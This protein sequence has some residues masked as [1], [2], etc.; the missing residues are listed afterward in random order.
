MSTTQ[1]IRSSST[2]RELTPA[3]RLRAK[4]L[5][6]YFAKR[7]LGATLRY[8]LLI[9]LSFLILYPFIVKLSNS[10]M[11][12]Q[13]LID[14]TVRFIPRNFTL[15]NYK[16]VI[17]YTDFLEG[18]KN[19]FLISFLSGILQMIVCTVIGYGLAKFRF[20]G[21][22][23]VSALVVLT[24]L[25]PPQTYMISLFLRF[26]F[27]DIF[28]IAEALTGD[29]IRILD[30][31]WPMAILSLTGFGFKNGLYILIMRQFFRGIPTELEEAAY[32]DGSGLFRTFVTIILPLSISMMTTIFLFAFAW[33]WTDVFYSSVFFSRSM[34]L[35]S[36]TL[37]VGF[38]GLMIPGKTLGIKHGQPIT[39]TLTNTM[40]LLVIT[41][42]V[43]I[44]LF[45]QKNL[46]EGIER[47][48]IVG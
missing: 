12:E 24:I 13:D 45:A 27:F 19:T 18:F 10:F 6:I 2:K 28:G 16:I 25:M 34:K 1:I 8:W 17:E 32:V 3:E 22:G 35:L 20:R 46:V 40:S 26:R 39:A 48:G 42:L 31:Y 33:Q 44:Y 23:I 21:R 41:P 47:S 7:L 29:T 36:N 9:G 15:D 14:G 30:T 4:Y 5:N 11:S 37:L 43:I 38:E